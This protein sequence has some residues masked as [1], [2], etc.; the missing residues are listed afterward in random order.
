MTQNWHFFGIETRKRR[1]NDAG[2]LRNRKYKEY[3]DAA[4]EYNQLKK[5]FYDV[6]HLAILDG[7][8]SEIGKKMILEKA[9]KIRIPQIYFYTGHFVK[10]K[11]QLL[12]GNNIISKSN[13]RVRHCKINVLNKMICWSP[14]RYLIP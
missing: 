10:G 2:T 1:V 4:F 11:I 6:T 14:V 3:L 12:E 8:I 7:D 13:I 5:A 9:K